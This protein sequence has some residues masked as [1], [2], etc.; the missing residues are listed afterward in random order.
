MEDKKISVIR[1]LAL[2]LLVLLF[3][4]SNA[5]ADQAGSPPD[6]TVVSPDGKHIFVM[7]DQHG[8]TELGYPASG[9]YLNDGSREPL[10]TVDWKAFVSVPSGGDVILRHGTWPQY[11]GRYEE[12]A[13]SF[14]VRGQ[15]VRTYTAREIVDFPWLLPHTVSHYTWGLGWCEVD[16]HDGIRVSGGATYKNHGVEF[17]GSGETAI[18]R[19][20]LG[21]QLTFDLRTGNLIRPISS[22][23]RHPTLVLTLLFFVFA[24]VVYCYWRLRSATRFPAGSVIRISNVLVGLVMALLLLLAPPVI[25]NCFRLPDCHGSGTGSLGETV[26]L[27]F[28]TFPFYVASDFGYT[29][30]L[31]LLSTEIRPV[32]FI[33]WIT[34]V[35]GLAIFDRAIVA[36]F[37]WRSFA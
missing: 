3:G 19:T 13:I 28:F 22:W 10:W 5:L 30:S 24:I 7:A 29:P 32:V 4:A 31:P 33:F 11:S 15:V 34:C 20:A 14:I 8:L 16:G 37:K 12:E 6:F 17:D 27:A 25:A 18:V 36:L 1:S 23:S 35:F 9:M 26:L 21:D 2:A